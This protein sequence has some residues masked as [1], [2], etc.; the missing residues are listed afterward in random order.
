MALSDII[1]KIKSEASVQANEHKAEFK[2][3]K[4]EMEAENIRHLTQMEKDSN[5]LTEKDI[6]KIKEK[7]EMEAEMESKNNLLNAKRQVIDAVLKKA[8]VTLATT[9]KYEEILTQMLRN[10]DM[11][12]AQ[13]IP[14]KGK[15]DSTRRAIE[16]SGKNFTLVPDEGVGKDFAGGFILKTDKIEIDNSFETIVN[17]ELRSQL[18][19]EL[20]KLLFV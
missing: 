19:I 20:N 1:E 17:Q 15:E 4:K 6:A 9:D 11:E 3:M 2:K 12:S 13:I 14:A 16:R 10:I 8:V 18:E 7:A 5:E